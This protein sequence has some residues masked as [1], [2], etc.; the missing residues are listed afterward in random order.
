M[1][2][3]NR[4]LDHDL[5]PFVLTLDGQ[6]LKKSCQIK[7]LVITFDP[8]LNL[9]NHITSIIGKAKTRL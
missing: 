6:V 8:K 2:I 4:K 1:Q 9:N 3:T 7:D 5:A